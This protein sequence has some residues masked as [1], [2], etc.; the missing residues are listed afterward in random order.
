MDAIEQ[1][2]AN[3]RKYPDTK[4]ESGADFIRVF[5]NSK[6]GFKVE[7]TTFKS[8]YT[9]HFNG[10]HE[11]FK[12]EQEALNCFTFG[13]SAQCRLKEYRRWNI[14]YKWTVEYKETDK[15]V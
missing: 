8:N 5:P 12:D 15:W 14:A 1:I 9:V 3:L 13:L 2:T 6:N 4:Y 10:W 7:L 11:N